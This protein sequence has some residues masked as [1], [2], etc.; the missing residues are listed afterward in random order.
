VQFISNL[1]SKP[2][3]CDDSIGEGLIAPEPKG[4]PHQIEL[5]FTEI[6]EE[7][8]ESESHFETTM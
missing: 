6:L 8:H 3:V 1:A 7:E 2:W 5:K 4:D